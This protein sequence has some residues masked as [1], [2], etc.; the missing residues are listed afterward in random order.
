MDITEFEF[1][2]TVG[3]SDVIRHKEPKTVVEFNLDAFES[4]YDEDWADGGLRP[5]SFTTLKDGWY[6]RDRAYGNTFNIDE[7]LQI[8]VDDENIAVLIVKDGQI[9]ATV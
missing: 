2:E 5:V 1:E 4:E 8:G 6:I 7:F 3:K 9:L